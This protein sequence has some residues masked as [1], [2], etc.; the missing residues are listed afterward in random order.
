MNRSIK[1]GKQKEGIN[2]DKS[3]YWWIWTHTK[4]VELINY[5][6][7]LI[8]WKTSK[9]YTPLPHLIKKEIKYTYTKLRMK[10]M[11]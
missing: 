8:L 10:K 9:I 7:E 4:T 5:S 3:R 1:Q 2:K 11:I 6:Q